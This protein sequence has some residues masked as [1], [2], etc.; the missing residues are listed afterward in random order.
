MMS[1]A[2]PSARQYLESALLDER[3]EVGLPRLVRRLEPHG[4]ERHL[5]PHERHVLVLCLRRNS[6]SKLLFIKLHVNTYVT[7]LCS[8]SPFYPQHC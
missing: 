3:P 7:S 6:G 2:Y 5:R 4:Q 1:R 8:I